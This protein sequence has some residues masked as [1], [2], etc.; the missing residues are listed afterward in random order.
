[1][2]KRICF[3]N[4]NTNEIVCK[5]QY[6]R[7]CVQVVSIAK[8]NMAGDANSK[9]KWEPELNTRIELIQETIQM[10]FET[11]KFNIELMY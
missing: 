4:L 10:L 3:L 8:E 11:S 1:M 5:M 2:I 6:F 9:Q 7:I